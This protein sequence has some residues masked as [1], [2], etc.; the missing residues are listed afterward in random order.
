MAS[1]REQKRGERGRREKETCNWSRALQN[2]AF[3]SGTTASTEPS[4]SICSGLGSS[5]GRW[6]GHLLEGCTLAAGIE[7]HRDQSAARGKECCRK[8]PRTPSLFSKPGRVHA[9]ELGLQK[10]ATVVLQAKNTHATLGAR[11]SSATRA[12]L[13]KSWRHY[14]CRLCTYPQIRSCQPLDRE[15]RGG[16]KPLRAPIQRGLGQTNRQYSGAQTVPIQGMASTKGK[17]VPAF[18]LVRVHA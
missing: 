5:A 13:G 11:F 3:Q 18:S 16:K 17:I 4:A 6:S 7:L 12:A 9:R 1:P 15:S 2:G 8:P 14:A 10:K